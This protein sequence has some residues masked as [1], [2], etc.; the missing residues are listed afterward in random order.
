MNGGGRSDSTPRRRGH[1]G[2]MSAVVLFVLLAAVGMPAGAG[3]PV[4]LPAVALC[5]GAV[6]HAARAVTRAAAEPIRVRSRQHRGLPRPPL[7]QRS[8]AARGLPPTRA[9]TG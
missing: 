2:L 6:A 3:N 7:R 8:I 9:P 5:D 4:D 1:L